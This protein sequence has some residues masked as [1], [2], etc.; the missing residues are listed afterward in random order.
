MKIELN[1]EP[2]QIGE[3]VIDVFKTLT[4]EDK[5]EMAIQI[6]REWLKE[7]SLFESC[8]FE[9]QLI[10]EYRTGIR[11]PNSTYDKFDENTPESTIRNDYYFKKSVEEYKTSKQGL[12]EATKR[13]MLV[14]YNEEIAKELKLDVTINKIKEETYKE[15]TA[16]FPRIITEVLIMAFSSNLANM[17]HQIQD[18]TMKSY[19]VNS[20]ID[21]V[22]GKLNL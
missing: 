22:R 3:T 8:N 15:L 13:E 9:Q 6:M 14:Y 19:N 17:Q 12:V 11:K 16:N 7:P 1:I 20:F 4:P 18:M 2:S 21:Q 10:H 5:K